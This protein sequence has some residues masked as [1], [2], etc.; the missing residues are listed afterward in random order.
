MTDFVRVKQN[1]TKHEL[2]VPVEHYEANKDG[3]TKLDKPAADLGGAP[4]PTKHHTTPGQKAA[5][6]KENS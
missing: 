5:S 6:S 1:D 4:L 2:S 3:Y